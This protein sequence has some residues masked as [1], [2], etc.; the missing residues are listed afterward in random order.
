M[1]VWRPRQG[2]VGV[3]GTGA[4][5]RSTDIPSRLQGAPGG[6]DVKRESP[7]SL[8]SFAQSLLCP[9][10]MSQSHSSRQTAS[11]D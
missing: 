9:H 8:A 11:V 4:G 10:P 6:S 7:A 1:F 5:P 2:Q 3:G